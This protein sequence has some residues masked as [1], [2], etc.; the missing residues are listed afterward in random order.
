MDALFGLFEAGLILWNTKESNKYRDEYIRLNKAYYE[1]YN[2]TMDFR[3]DAVLD[4]L[5]FQLRVLAIA[6]ASDVRKSNLAPK[7]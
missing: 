1:E 5:Q 3:S 7:S 4:N 2:K 6:F